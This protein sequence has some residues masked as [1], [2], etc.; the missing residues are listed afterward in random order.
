[1]KYIT[2]IIG[3]LVVGCG[4]VENGAY[5]HRPKKADK[6]ESTPPTNTNKVNGPRVHPDGDVDLLVKELTPEEKKVVGEYELV[7]AEG[8]TFKLVFLENR[9]VEN[10][11][12]GEKFFEGTWKIVGK[13]VHTETSG[14]NTFGKSEIWVSKIE[15]N[16]DLAWIAK[17]KDG[18][19]KDYSKEEQVVLKKKK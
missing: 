4:E 18:K 16:G 9:K 1:M 14:G 3:L 6:N 12:N 19:R 7:D 2:L 11:M 17:F 8:N 5:K 10:Y 13:E 15:P